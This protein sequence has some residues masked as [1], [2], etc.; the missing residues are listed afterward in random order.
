MGVCLRCGPVL[1]HTGESGDGGEVSWT[2]QR[3][4]YLWPELPLPT[5]E[6]EEL[7][8]VTECLGW[9]SAQCLQQRAPHDETFSLACHCP[10]FH[11]APTS[12]LSDVIS[13][14]LVSCYTVEDSQGTSCTFCSMSLAFSKQRLM[15]VWQ[16]LPSLLPTRR[17]YTWAQ[18]GRIKGLSNFV[19]SLVVQWFQIHLPMQETWVRFLVGEDPTCRRSAK[20]A[21]TT[22]TEPV[23]CVSPWAT[24]YWDHTRQLLKPAHL[25]P[26]VHNERSHSSEK[27]R[28]APSPKLKKRL[29]FQ[30]G[31][32]TAKKE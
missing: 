27:W 17:G 1:Q 5:F 10:S 22:A 13:E 4:P 28:V 20:P 16:G 18:R 2:W 26:A 29:Q 23:L 3:T 32:S 30:Q 15:S 19:A 31:P 21:C 11:A 8:C 12:G 7:T 9:L 24:T 14:S 25:E 6:K